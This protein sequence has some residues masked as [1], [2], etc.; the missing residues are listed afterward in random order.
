MLMVGRIA[1]A[2][3]SVIALVIALLV[4]KFELGGIME[5]VSAAWSIFGAAFGP[6]ILLALY[7]KRL[8]YKGA[9][10]GIISGFAVSILWMILFNLGYY[11][12]SAVI[13]ETGLYEIVP[14]FIVGLAVAIVVSL[15]TEKPAA[16]VEELFDAV[17]NYSEE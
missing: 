15:T 11:G 9:C 14:G 10:A 4:L 8:N 6:V 5:L 16:E 3:I 1:V 2:V 12:F 17:K 13:A 7:W